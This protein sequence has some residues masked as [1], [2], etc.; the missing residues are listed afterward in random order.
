MEKEPLPSRSKLTEAV[1]VDYPAA[2][3]ILVSF[4]DEWELIERMRREDTPLYIAALPPSV[5]APRRDQF[6]GLPPEINLELT[7]YRLYRLFQ[8]WPMPSVVVSWNETTGTGQVE[9]VGDL[10]V[11]LRPLGQAQAW[12]GCTVG[13]IW[14]CYP[15]ETGRGDN[16][17][18]ELTAFWR[19]VEQDMGAARTFTQPH[20]PTWEQ[21]YTD[22]LSRL[23]YAPAPACPGWWSI[24][25]ADQPGREERWQTTNG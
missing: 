18:A 11:Q 23:G 21:G 14:E 24:E 9:Q 25:R 5:E 13:V 1:R 20:E 8:P 19:T 7:T 12:W 6:Y 10:K 17:Q 22:F 16:W 15:H 4:P 3:E 2:S